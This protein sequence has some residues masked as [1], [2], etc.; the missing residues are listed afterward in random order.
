MTPV[1]MSITIGVGTVIFHHLLAS[2]SAIRI[3]VTGVLP[4]GPALVL[5]Y[6][7]VKLPSQQ[8]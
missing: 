5:L 6:K 1:S 3:I 4:V 2:N 7:L 8:R